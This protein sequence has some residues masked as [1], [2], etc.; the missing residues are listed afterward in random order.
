MLPDWGYR[1]GQ[2]HF[3]RIGDSFLIVSPG[4]LSLM[5]QSPNAIHQIT[6]RRE[7]FPKSTGH[8]SILEIYGRNIVTTEGA[9]WRFHR[10]ATS[11]SFNEKNAA[12]T[13]AEAIR[14]AQGMLGQWT[15]APSPTITTIERDTM[16]LALNII[17][18]VGFGLRLTWPGERLPDDTDAWARKYGSVT[19]P[20]GHTMTFATSVASVLHRIMLLLILPRW[21]LR[22][23]GL[24]MQ[25]P[26]EAYDA[27][28]NY[29]RYMHEFL[30]DKVAAAQQGQR[31]D[32]GMDLMGQLVRARYEDEK[33]GGGGS[34]SVGGSTLTDDEIIGNAFIM[35]VAGHETTA[36]SMHFAL[37]ELACKPASQRALQADIDRLLGRDSDPTTWNYDASINGMLASMLGAVMNETLRLMPPVVNVP[38]LVSPQADQ[39]L[40]LPETGATHV[41]PAGID[42]VLSVVTA[43]RHPKH[44]P[45]APGQKQTDLD[46]FVPER[47]FRAADAKDSKDAK[48]SREIDGADTEDYGGPEGPDTSAQ[49]FRPVRGSFT[50]FSDGPRSC[51]GRRIAQVEMLAALAVLFQRYSIELAVDAWADDGAVAAMDAPAR[52]AL[53]AQA[54]ASAHETLRGATTL[55]TLKLH[56]AESVP[57]RLV[58]RGAE[59]FVGIVDAS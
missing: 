5:T 33:R 17:G 18:Y 42:V 7:H 25:A 8:Y 23:L 12:H 22:V 57:V 31:G 37:I 21:L 43:H 53:Y 55:L 4:A 30:A 2:E 56:G 27:D 19:P 29:T 32:G 41:L 13:F 39:T 50:P 47:W 49:L 44:W 45:A 35:L 24:A 28:V 46:D 26:R 11:A 15:T 38:K 52:R 10:K 3:E 59:R 16:T 20:P 34:P 54:Q 48:D 51:L 1:T 14:Q 36:N 6:S 9:V 40:A 58:P